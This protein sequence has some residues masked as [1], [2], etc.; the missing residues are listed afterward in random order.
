[1]KKEA[2]NIS[3]NLTIKMID[4]I[5]Q[6]DLFQGNYSTCCIRVGEPNSIAMCDYLMNTAFNMIELVDNETGKTIGN[7]LCYF[8]RD[9]KGN[10]LFVVDNIEINNSCKPSSNAGLELRNKIFEYASNVAKSVTGKDT[11][12]VMSKRYNDVPFNDLVV[13]YKKLQLLG[14]TESYRAYM[15]LFDGWVNARDFQN[16]DCY[17]M[18]NSSENSTSLFNKILSW[19][20]LEP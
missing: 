18:P 3:Y 5:P 7:A 12:I 4:R 17:Q 10:L 11:K 19:L 20:H 9:K 15:D 16:A 13:K 1:M 14:K 8:V 6:K 2:S